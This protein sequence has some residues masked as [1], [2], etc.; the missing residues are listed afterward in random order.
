MMLMQKLSGMTTDTGSGIPRFSSGSGRWELY[1]PLPP[2]PAARPRV[3][4]WGTY[5]PKTYAGWRKLVQAMLMDFEPDGPAH[6][7]PMFVGV[8]SVCKRPIRVTKPLPRG[9]VDNFSK[10]A[11]DAVTWSE[12]IWK[13]DT[14]VEILVTGKRYANP[15]ED[16]HTYIV[17]ST[18]AEDITMSALYDDHIVGEDVYDRL[19][20]CRVPLEDA[21][22]G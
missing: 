4:R 1:L 11:L 3:G 12:L 9:D 17:V 10:G 18:S 16:P 14:Q 6:E 5:Y 2:V 8:Y 21:D 7:G 20:E 13:D 22:N 15:G 19:T